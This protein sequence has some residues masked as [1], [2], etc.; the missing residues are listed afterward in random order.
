VLVSTI[1][2]LDSSCLQQTDDGFFI[3]LWSESVWK[4]CRFWRS[5]ITRLNLEYALSSREL[6]DKLSTPYTP[7]C[8]FVILFD[9]AAASYLQPGN[10]FAKTG[11]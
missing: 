7:T 10:G 8:K 1:Y 5:S 4:S 6:G 9:L 11:M 3:K 2:V